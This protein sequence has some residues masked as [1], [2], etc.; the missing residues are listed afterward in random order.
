MAKI[1]KK[2]WPEYFAK[3]RGWKAHARLADF[4]AKRGDTIVF[5]EW[6]PKSRSFT[7]RKFSRR[8]TGVNKIRI[9][10]FYSAKEIKKKGLQI[11]EVR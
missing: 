6:D 3:A 1:I 11:I 8:V 7:G 10:K 9:A 4:A 5:A 2:L